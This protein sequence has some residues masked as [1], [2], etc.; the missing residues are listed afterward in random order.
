MAVCSLQGNKKG[1]QNKSTEE[2]R[3]KESMEVSGLVGFL[4][5]EYANLDY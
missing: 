2:E 5:S 1:I 3:R 4:L